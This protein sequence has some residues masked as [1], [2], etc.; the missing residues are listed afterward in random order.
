MFASLSANLTI[1]LVS[2]LD[3]RIPGYCIVGYKK[4]DCII[5]IF[6][7]L[8]IAVVSFWHLESSYEFRLY[9]TVNMSLLE[10]I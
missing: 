5:Y 2:K 3:A 8:M 6:Q 1:Q 10:L 9:A 7:F 4:V